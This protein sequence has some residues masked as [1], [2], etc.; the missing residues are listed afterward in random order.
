M[1]AIDTHHGEPQ[2]FVMHRATGV[3][4]IPQAWLD[5]WRPSGFREARPHEVLA[6]Y[7]ERELDPPAAVLRAVHAAHAAQ[8]RR[9]LGA[10]DERP[11]AI[12]LP[13]AT[14]GT[15]RVPATGT[16]GA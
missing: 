4:V 2:V 7:D 9:E 5:A 6:W 8:D 11:A 13:A 15:V 14:Q 16:P 3:H 1:V 10:E 12:T